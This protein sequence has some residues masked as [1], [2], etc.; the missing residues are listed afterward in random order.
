MTSAT[1]GSRGARGAPLGAL[2]GAGVGFFLGRLPGALIGGLLGHLFQRQMVAPRRP[3]TATRAVERAAALVRLAVAVARLDGPLDADERE[4]LRSYFHRDAGLPPDSLG[5]VDR[6]ID[7]ALAGPALAPAEAARAMPPLDGPDRIHVLFVLF[8]IALADRALQPVE[9]EALSAAARALGLSAEDY[10]GVKAH[11]VA[12]GAGGA[13]DDFALF[14]LEP[15]ADLDTVKEKYR[16]AARNY[17][18]DRFQH[19]GHEFTSVATEKFQRI[20]EAYRRI[21]EGNGSH[22]EETRLSVCTSCRSF[23]PAA[24]ATCPACGAAKFLEQDDQVRIRCPFCTQV[25]G[26]PRA[27]LSGQVRCGNCKVLLVR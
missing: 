4:A 14:G 10:E 24:L 21:L 19:L 3:S 12:S 20:Q 23:S 1:R 5:G 11:F 18:P 26:L 7:A 25:N 8:R 16:E 2:L 15:G 6:M 9:A 27:A 13:A 17:H 22:I